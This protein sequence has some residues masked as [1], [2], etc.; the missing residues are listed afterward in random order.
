MRLP[1]SLAPWAKYLQIF[2]EEISLAI[3]GYVQKI[4]PFISPLNS[5][6]KISK[7]EP[8]GYDGVARR[9]I[10][11]RL[12]LSEL[13]LADE[14]P[15][16]FIRRAVMGEH[17]FLQ[18]AEIAPNAKRVS[19]A[20]FDAGAMQLGA[21]RIA[22]IA[23]F[24]VLARR[25]EAANSMFLWSAL[26]DTKQLVISDDTE[27]SIKLLLEARTANDVT[28]EDISG[29]RE[30]LSEIDEMG[31]VWLIGS[32]ELSQFEKAKVFSHLYVD[33]VPQLEKREIAL[34]IKSA[35]GAEKQTKLELPSPDICTRLLRNPFEVPK[36]PE[37]SAA[38]L[39]ANVS[40]FFFDPQGAKLFARLDSD[41][42]LC[43]SVENTPDK[44]KIYPTT[45]KPTYSGRYIAAGRLRKATAVVMLAEDQKLWLE[46]RKMGF[47]LKQGY[48]KIRKG[49]FALPEDQKELLQIYNMRP[50]QFHYDEAG[51]LD[52][53]G[54]LFLMSQATESDDKTIAGYA[55]LTATNVLAA[56]HTHNE[57]IFV[58]CEDGNDH[59]RIVAISNKI[60]RREVPVTNPK[61]ALFGR[62]ESGRKV[63]A[64]QSDQNN[65]VILTERDE[66]QVMPRP[67]GEVVG[68]YSN[69]R[70]A[71]KPGLF[72]L[73]D[74]RRTLEFTWAYGRRKHILEEKEE[75]VKIEFCPLSPIFA[76]QTVTGEL[77]IYSITHRTAVGRYS[78]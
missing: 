17:L 36:S 58:G 3:G 41:D 38:N 29:W 1:A 19:I 72:E 8:N 69:S 39:G 14:V 74:D 31:D 4:S 68:V 75:I 20:L 5:L 40:N 27:A 76:Y 37:F 77:V 32:P 22:H 65:W 34:R 55:T 62:G 73:R 11:E 64:V 46:Y 33:E 23:A 52:A 6:D 50:Q 48:Y 21:P 18:L 45:Y 54:N 61:R 53:G 15:D 70:V 26:Q 67:K 10:Y 25:A 66:V 60:E 24:I 28:E 71:P 9:G 57:F 30:K 49:E 7:G 78:K 2:P 42:I 47:G 12:L 16:E 63:L 44:G 43:F 13:A 59:H 56:T 51:I 35:S